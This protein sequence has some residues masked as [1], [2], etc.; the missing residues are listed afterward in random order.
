MGASHV[1]LDSIFH[2]PGWTP[3]GDEEFRAR[4][5]E[6]TAADRWVVDGNYSVVHGIV[7][8][9]ADS[10]VWFDLPYAT[11]LF[12]T[13]GAVERQP[14]AVLEPVVAQPGEVD[15]RLGR[16]AARC[17]PAA[18]RGGR[19]RPALG[20]SALRQAALASGSRPIR[21]RRDYRRPMKEE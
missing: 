6:A 8:D 1:E 21:G 9:N 16:H 12:R 5:A 19:A 15:H 11:V 3:L 2:Q 4:V 20:A 7:W 14:R 13:T 10:V 18:L 17:L